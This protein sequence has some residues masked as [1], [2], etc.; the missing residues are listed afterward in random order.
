MNTLVRSIKSSAT[1][2]G[3]WI[4]MVASIGCA[5]HCAAMP[6][7]IASLPALGLSFLADESFHQWMAVACFGIALAAFVPGWKKHRRLAPAAIATVGLVMICSAA[8][9]MAGDCCASCA[10]VAAEAEAGDASSSDLD[11][12][13]A[14]CEDGCCEFC[15]AEAATEDTSDY[16]VSEVADTQGVASAETTA[17]T[18]LAGFGPTSGSSLLSTIGPWLTP[19]GGLILVSAHLLNR[20]FGCLCGCCGTETNEVNVQSIG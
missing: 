5:I 6:F 18:S 16:A 14:V 19:I 8:F 17:A 11:A 7:V 20:R 4:G 15:A 12:T 13:E 10:A 9:G 1:N 3:D 2:W